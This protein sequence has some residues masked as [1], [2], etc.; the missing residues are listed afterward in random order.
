VEAR[1]SLLQ[2]FGFCAA[3]MYLFAVAAF[4]N[5][6]GLLHL[7]TKLY[8]STI[9]GPAAVFACLFSGS[10]LRGLRSTVGKLWICFFAWLMIDI[11]FS[12][13]KSGSLT[14]VSAYGNS[15]MIFFFIC[16]SATSWKRCRTILYVLA[17]AAIAVLF[18]CF[19]FGAFEGARFALPDG[20]LANPN[21]L[22]LHL[23]ISLAILLYLFSQRN[24]FLG[25]LG[26]LS[27]ALTILYI[28][29]S[30]SR[31]T[32]VALVIL[33]VVLFFISSMAVRIRLAA[34][35]AFLAV[36][37]IPF[38]P[39]ATLQRL[40][41]IVVEEESRSGPVDADLA[42]QFSRERLLKISL[43][44]TL[45]HPLFGVGPGQF[46]SATF[47]DAV[48]AGEWVP[49]MGTHNAY[50]QISSECGIPALVFYCGVILLCLRSNYRVYKA[51][52]KTPSLRPIAELALCLFAALLAYAVNTFFAHIAYTYYLPALSGLSVSLKMAVDPLLSQVTAQTT[53]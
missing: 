47:S 14:Q 44:Y 35:T 17:A 16:A 18:Y 13:W 15:W 22:A 51:A 43:L 3:C 48:K 6:M 46:S 30:G 19:Q 37:T 27:A 7:G 36:V 20:T 23:L 8:L 26:F 49:W 10:L 53:A 45:Q 31:G 12:T 4:L 34:L 29:L 32:F 39:V 21:D 42:S 25:F 33:C 2:L 38:V 11:L 41:R 1:G 28:F 9:A 52:R 40:V 50:T 5:E 24:V